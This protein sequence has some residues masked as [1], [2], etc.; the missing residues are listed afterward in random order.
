MDLLIPLIVAKKR[1]FR[2]KAHDVIAREFERLRPCQGSSAGGYRY[3][4]TVHVLNGF[5][6]FVYEDTAVRELDVF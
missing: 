3:V 4:C 5:A 1:L 2:V 6:R